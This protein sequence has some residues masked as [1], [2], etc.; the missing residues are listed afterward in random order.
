M[1]P[2]LDE[3]LPLEPLDPLSE[4]PLDP[5]VA[6][7]PLVPPESLDPLDPLVPPWS[8]PPF[9]DPPCFWCCVRLWWVGVVWPVDPAC[10]VPK[11]GASGAPASPIAVSDA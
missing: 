9:V 4:E 3:P 8:S 5:L 7:E 2:L 10:V 6:L 1:E 11:C